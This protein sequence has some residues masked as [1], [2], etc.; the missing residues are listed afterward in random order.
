MCSAEP[1]SQ[2]KRDK[3][4]RSW[5]ARLTDNFGM[6]E[7]GMMGSESK[8]PKRDTAFAL[9]TAM[10]AIGL[11]FASGDDFRFVFWV[12]VI[13]A[14]IAVERWAALERPALD[15]G[16]I[17]KMLLAGAPQLLENL[18][19][20]R[21]GPPA[22]H[23][24]QFLNPFFLLSRPEH[25]RELVARIGESNLAPAAVEAAYSAVPG[26]TPGDRDGPGGAPRVP[27]KSSG[28]D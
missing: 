17:K 23:G 14:L 18:D 3:I 15:R 28:D 2:A 12:A 27:A 19:P 16:V 21:D 26:S 20:E 10:L 4:E 11:M 8:D 1:V 22:L 6:T 25:V 5:N 24:R 9:I 13:P 7:A